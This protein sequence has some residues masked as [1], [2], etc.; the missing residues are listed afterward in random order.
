MSALTVVVIGVIYRPLL[1]SSFSAELTRA[2][3]INLRAVGLLF[4]IAMAVAVGLSSIAVGSILSTALLIG[5]AAASVR[6]TNSL[7]AA[8]LLA[9]ALG[10]V[11]TWL[12]ILFAYDSYYWIPSGKALPVS[13]FI[14]S[15]IFV[16]YLISGLDVVRRGLGWS[17]ADP[18]SDLTPQAT[19]ALASTVE[20]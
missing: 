7:R 9:S 16:F 3:G 18:T 5:P 11:A 2:R 4:M 15:L 8:M 17:K 14:V 13:F 10:V 12:G 20:P 1:L 6:L 19:P